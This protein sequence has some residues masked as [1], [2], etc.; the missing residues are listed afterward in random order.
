MLNLTLLEN[1]LPLSFIISHMPS[2]NNQPSCHRRSMPF[3][4][5]WI[6]SLISTFSEICYKC[7]FIMCLFLHDLVFARK[8]TN[9]LLDL[10]DTS[11]FIPKSLVTPCLQSGNIH[12]I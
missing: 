1:F 12:L 9:Q 7:L 3:T 5:S 11:V 8:L 4:F 2:V 6:L 10:R